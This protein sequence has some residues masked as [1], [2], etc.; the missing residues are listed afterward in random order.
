MKLQNVVI[1]CLALCLSGCVN[2]PKDSYIIKGK[3]TNPILEGRTVY[4][5]DALNSNVKYDSAVVKN[6][7]FE[8]TGKQQDAVVRE[9]LVLENDSDRFPVTM[10][11]VLENGEIVAELGNRV[12][13]TNT[14]GNEEMMEFLMDKDRF[15]DVGFEG[16]TD[17]E[18]IKR[19]F[20]TFLSQ[21]IM[22]HGNSVV[23]KYIFE[24]YKDK[25]TV[26]EQAECERFVK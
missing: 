4:I 20:A 15:L 5:L 18:Q 7:V 26:E 10:P 6:G 25:L 11:F 12:Y 24:A 9:L 23:G 1:A 22:K 16:V 19:K 2:T 3:I 17:R 13:I 21:Q 8:F 14:K